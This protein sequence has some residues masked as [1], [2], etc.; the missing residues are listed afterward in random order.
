VYYAITIAFY[1]VGT[2]GTDLHPRMAL[3][4]A[5]IWIWGS[6]LTYNFYRK[7]GYALSG[8][9]Y[10]WKIIQQGVNPI[11][12]QIFNIVFIAFIQNVLLAS[13]VSP[14]YVAWTGS[15]NA[16]NILITPL[17]AID[18]LATVLALTCLIIESVADQQQWKFQTA[19]H[20]AIK[21]GKRLTGP[22]AKGF[23]DT[24]LFRYSR[25]PNFFAEQCFWWSMCLFATAATGKWYGWW[26]GGA[27]ALTALFQGSTWLT[28]KITAEKYPKYKD[29]QKTTSRLMLWFPGTVAATG[30]RSTAAAAAGRSP[31]AAKSPR[32][33]RSTAAALAVE[34]APAP[35]AVEEVAPAAAP[36]AAPR[37]RG[38]STT[39]RASAPAKK[40]AASR[41][42]SAA[43]VPKKAEAP[44]KKAA[45]ASPAKKP[46]APRSVSRGAATKKN[47]AAAAPKKAAAAAAAAS[48]AARRT[49]R[50][51]RA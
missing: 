15:Y 49:T 27:A 40:P 21:A 22:F 7:G 30:G 13:I 4:A 5:L 24:G 36:A 45:T 17:N 41:S 35:V 37:S 47:A 29:Y 48:P 26:M 51:R 43:S 9:D 18:L 19:K 6:R 25:H 44:K 31:A 28:E 11:L 1:S 8:E 3:I 39:R 46:A 2:F 14:V 20:A 42:R 16:L 34:A 10:R 38:R 33:R 32:G 23:I 12:F 50:S